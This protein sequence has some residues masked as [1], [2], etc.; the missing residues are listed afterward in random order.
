MQELVEKHQETCKS[1][2]DLIDKLTAD[3]EQMQTDK[4]TLATANLDMRVRLDEA[5]SQLEE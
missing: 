3:V 4:R 2:S 5:T 1:Q